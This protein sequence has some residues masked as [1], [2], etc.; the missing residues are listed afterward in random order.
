MI[1]RKKLQPAL[2]SYHEKRLRERRRI[3]QENSVAAAMQ[4]RRE[5][6]GKG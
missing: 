6:D 5:P 4:R 3:Q 2:T 1:K